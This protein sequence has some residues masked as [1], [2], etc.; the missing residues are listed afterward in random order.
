MS[1]KR[2]QPEG[3][4]GK[5]RHADVLLGHGKKLAEV[6]KGPGCQ[7][8]H[9]LSVPTRVRGN[10]HGLGQAPQRTRAREW[11]ASEDRRRSHPRQAD[12]PGGRQ[13][14]LLSPSG[15]R[16]CVLAVCEGLRVSERR[17]CRVLGQHQ[18]TQRHQAAPR[19]DEAPL[20]P[21]I[22]ELAT[23]YGPVRL[24]PDHG[25]APAGR[26]GRECEARGADLAPGGVEGAAAA[27][28]AGRPLAERRLLRPTPADTPESRVG[29]SSGTLLPNVPS[30]SSVPGSLSCRYR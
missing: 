15:R 25:V 13:G 16:A 21:T 4:I 17:A 6:V 26:L 27:A 8:R 5:L 12:L 18:T 11:P 29:L 22:I 14:K 3:I 2:F 9:L 20:T 28:E 30:D 1:K 24:S 10:V 19:S 23:Q 7:R